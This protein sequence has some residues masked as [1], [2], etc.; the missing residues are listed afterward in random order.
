MGAPRQNI[1]V[2]CNAQTAAENSPNAEEYLL[3]GIV[4][5]FEFQHTGLCRSLNNVQACPVEHQS[6]YNDHVLE[7]FPRLTLHMLN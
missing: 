5:A 4:L 6:V 1:M 7:Q 3:C 2:S